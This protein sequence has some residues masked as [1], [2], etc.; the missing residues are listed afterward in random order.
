MQAVNRERAACYPWAGFDDQGTYYNV[1]TDLFLDL[2]LG[3]HSSFA[4][5]TALQHLNRA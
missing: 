2:T 1:S 4:F 3:I 5:N